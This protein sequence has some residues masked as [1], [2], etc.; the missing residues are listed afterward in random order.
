MAE[1][2][3]LFSGPPG[4]GKTTAIGVISD[5][6]P[7]VTDVR[8]S[9]PT[10][11]KEMTTVGMDFG[12]ID[13]GEGDRVRLFGTPGQARFDF[14]WRVLAQNALGVVYLADNS[15]ADPL[16]DMATYLDVLAPDASTALVLGVGRT[17]AH[18]LPSLDDYAQ[19]L[20]AR[21]LVCPVLAVDVRQ[22]DDV[23]LLVDAL[24]NLV[25]S[26]G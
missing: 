10:L 4:A 14:M 21:G 11:H 25:D 2:K 9:D 15:A 23:L 6:A 24:L 22:R 13:L 26:A 5:V 18:P 3:I 12:E 1:Y 19:A 17:D 20:A 8:N 16:A 7:V